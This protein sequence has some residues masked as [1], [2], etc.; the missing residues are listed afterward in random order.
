MR[1]LFTVHTH[2]PCHTHEL[3]ECPC[4]D[5]PTTDRPKARGEEEEASELD[6]EY[7]TF[8][9]KFMS[10][11]QVDPEKLDRMDKAVR[12]L[13]H[14]LRSYTQQF[15]ITSARKEETGGS[16]CFGRMDTH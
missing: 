1:D 8:Q 11:T 12:Y 16:C 13:D 15:P 7:R 4:S 14:Q 3:L 9:A 10:A 5:G 2:S 6:S